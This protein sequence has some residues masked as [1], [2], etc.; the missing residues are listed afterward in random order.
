MS[1]KKFISLLSILF[2]TSCTTFVYK[3]FPY[4][5]GDTFDNDNPLVTPSEMH[6]LYWYCDYYFFEYSRKN[7]V[8]LFDYMSNT[9]SELYS[10]PIREVKDEDF[11]KIEEGMYVQEVVELVGLP[12]G[13]YTSGLLSLSFR[14]TSGNMHVIYFTNADIYSRFLIVM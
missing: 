11:D 4:K 12:F 14:S 6:D 7:Y 3:E 1:K 2:I 8:L 9:I 10:Y 5:V 13:S